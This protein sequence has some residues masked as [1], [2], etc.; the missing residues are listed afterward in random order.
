MI[1]ACEKNID[2]AIVGVYDDSCLMNGK[3]LQG[4]LARRWN[5]DVSGVMTSVAGENLAQS[6][7]CCCA[8]EC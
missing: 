7:A 2:C 4:R 8:S 6:A 1:V 5:D 3:H